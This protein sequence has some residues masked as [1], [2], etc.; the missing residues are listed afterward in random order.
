MKYG[1][2]YVCPTWQQLEEMVAAKG[3]GEQGSQ[4][5][6][7]LDAALSLMNPFGRIPVCGMISMYNTGP[8]GGDA[9]RQ[10]MHK[11]GQ[12]FEPPSVVR[13]DCPAD[14]SALCVALLSPEP[15]GVAE[16]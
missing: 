12:W 10:R 11:M 16:L 9:E 7:T 2:S 4:L 1:P 14:L 5:Q 6:L 3:K 8:V 13:P 15:D